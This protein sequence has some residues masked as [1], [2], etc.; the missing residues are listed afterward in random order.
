MHFVL[1][2][3]A[4]LC[5]LFSYCRTADGLREIYNNLLVNE[6]ILIS[7]CFCITVYAET[8]VLWSL[9]VNMENFNAVVRFKLI[10]VFPAS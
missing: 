3:N 7:L 8:N 4:Y 2:Y 5:F 10:S 6:E 1:Y 9:D